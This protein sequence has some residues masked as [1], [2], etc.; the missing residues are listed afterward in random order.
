M[1]TA[2]LN[3]SAMC[4]SMLPTA[5]TRTWPCWCCCT[6]TT[7]ASSADTESMTSRQRVSG[8]RP[9]WTLSSSRQLSSACTEC[10][11]T[12]LIL[13]SA[14][15]TQSGSAAGAPS[16]AAASEA[17]AARCAPHSAAARAALKPLVVSTYSTRSPWSARIAAAWRQSCV[18]PDAVSPATSVTL[19]SRSPT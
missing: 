17:I 11:R 8:A 10:G 12:T 6:P 14:S 16:S 9:S 15:S 3:S 5:P 2:M 7:G 13:S 1:S 19:P 4:R 18:L